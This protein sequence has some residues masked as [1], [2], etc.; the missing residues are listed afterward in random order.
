MTKKKKIL[1]IDM[2]NTICDFSGSPRLK[3][4]QEKIRN[5]SGMWE[6]GF[7]E[8]LQPLPGAMAGVREL[9]DCEEY[10]VWILTQPVSNSPRS[11]MEKA[12]WILKY[13]P[14]LKD[15]LIMTQDKNLHIGDVL[16][17]DDKRW[18][19]FGGKFVYFNRNAHPY[20]V[21]QKIV[22]MLVGEVDS[23]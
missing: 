11:Y 23:E 4:W 8:D 22:S 12:N 9:L 2:D 1:Y 10:D 17:D 13:L 7:F 6:S 20:T 21:W 5:P 3:D 15:K 18:K 14:E 19:D 16:I